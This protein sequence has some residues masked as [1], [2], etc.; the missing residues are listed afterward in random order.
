ME[1]NGLNTLRDIAQKAMPSRETERA[2]EQRRTDVAYAKSQIDKSN[3]WLQNNKAMPPAERLENWMVETKDWMFTPDTVE[4]YHDIK[5]S[6]LSSATPGSNGKKTNIADVQDELNSFTTPEEATAFY[7][8]NAHKWSR[9]I[10]NSLGDYFP[11]LFDLQAQRDLENSRITQT[12]AVKDVLRRKSLD[13]DPDVSLETH[14]QDFLKA[15]A[16]DMADDITT[17]DGRISIPLNGKESNAYALDDP[18]TGAT[19]KFIEYSDLIPTVT[20]LIKESLE[21]ARKLSAD[22]EELVRKTLYNK[23]SSGD[24]P[25][26]FAANVII[27]G[28]PDVPSALNSIKNMISNR[29]KRG[30]FQKTGS[31]ARAFFEMYEEVGK[32]LQRR[33]N[34]GK[35]L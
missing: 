25:S 29:G 22:S 32:T 26:Q 6:L 10:H 30:E 35:V 9:D 13:L 14:V 3:Q 34:G 16:Y 33:L 12:M 28:A 17:P 24:I 27:D 19:E 4:Y 21:E 11:R 31:S 15:Y 2:E 18:P 8:D 1:T 23:V 20:P 5:E 7:R